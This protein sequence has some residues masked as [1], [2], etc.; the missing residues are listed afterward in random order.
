MS[1][2]RCGHELG[3]GRFCL[4][5]GHPVGEPRPA[6]DLRP[7]IGEDEPLRDAADRELPS[8]LPWA[9][10]AILVVILLAVLASCLGGSDDETSDTSGDRVATPETQEPAAPAVDLTRGTEISAP[11]AAP[12]TADLDG[13]LVSYGAGRMLDANASTAWR[14]AG[15]AT[16]QVITFTLSQPSSVRRV[17]LING[18]A[19]QVPS[20]SSLV[21]WYPN[22][23]RITEVEWTFDDGTVVRQDLREKATMQRLTIEPETTQSVQLR[24]LSVTPPG[25]SVL[26]RDYTAISEVLITGTPAA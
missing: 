2:V 7:D 8:W 11:P 1:C 10:G 15:D 9:I 20:G 6:D 17:G 24:L 3:V 18:Y 5:C 26:G 22:N 4:N 25:A 19:R 14:T 21:D 12:P 13:Q 23:R 16:G